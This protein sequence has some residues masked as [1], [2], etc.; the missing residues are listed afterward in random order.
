VHTR[1]HMATMKALGNAA[2]ARGDFTSA[3]QLFRGAISAKEDDPATLYRCARVEL[4]QWSSRRRW[5]RVSHAPDWCGGLGCV[6]Q[7]VGEPATHG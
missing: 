6:Q 3:V 5:P 2:F 7:S 4:L 1:S